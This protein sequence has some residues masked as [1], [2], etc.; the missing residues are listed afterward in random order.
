[1]HD[2]GIVFAGEYI[3][4]STHIRGKLV[5]FVEATIDHFTHDQRI[6]KI[7]DDE[8]IGLGLSILVE[9]EINAADPKPLGLK[10]PNKMSANKAARAKHQRFLHHFPPCPLRPK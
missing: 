10:S 6:S 1:M 8:I 7:P 2:I 5:D 9:L 3:S 4:G